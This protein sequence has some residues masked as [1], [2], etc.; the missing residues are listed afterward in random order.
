LPTSELKYGR[1]VDSHAQEMGLQTGDN[2]EKVGDLEFTRYNPGIIRSEIGIN[3][4]KT[5]TVDRNGSEVTIDVDPRFT[6]IL[7][8]YEFKDAYLVAPRMPVEIMQVVKNKI[9]RAS[10]REGV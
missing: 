3:N 6:Q 5:I 8:G 1:Q 4:E 7:T 2:I 10:C 9:G